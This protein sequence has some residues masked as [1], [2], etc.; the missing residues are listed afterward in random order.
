MAL[1]LSLRRAMS[2]DPRIPL[3]RSSRARA[4]AL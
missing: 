3:G 2:Q 1:Q 4:R